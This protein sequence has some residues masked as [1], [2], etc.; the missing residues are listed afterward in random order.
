MWSKL[1]HWFLDPRFRWL[2]LSGTAVLLLGC[3]YG[4]YRLYQIGR[5]LQS[6]DDPRN[7]AFIQWATAI[8]S[9]DTATRAALTTTQRQACPGAPFILPSDGF[10]GLF[11]ADPRA[12]Y[13]DRHPHQGIDIFSQTDPGLT[14]VYAAIDGHVT[15]E[16]T[17]KSALIIR[18]PSDPLQP[19]RQI[20]LY[21]AHMADRQGHSFIDPAFPP[22]TSDYFV[23]QG[24]LLGYTGD[25]NGDS[26]R[27]VW[28]HLHFSI[29]L[30]DGHGRYRNELDIA[31]TLDPTP[32]L[33]LPL[34]YAHAR[35]P[36]ACLPGKS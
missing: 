13:S 17:W 29:V 25:Y 4:A 26:P 9:D 32:Y 3:L 34:N 1:Q 16:A 5:Y 23:T 36:V 31:N 7:Q 28:T 12:P 21:Y 35:P 18:V 14:P 11:Y 10:I 19:D 20:W 2:K 27:G 24:T 33:G 30:D 15:R 8:A 22:G 6:L